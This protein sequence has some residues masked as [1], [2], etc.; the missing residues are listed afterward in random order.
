MVQRKEIVRRGRRGIVAPLAVEAMERA[1]DLEEVPEGARDA[2]FHAYLMAARA[3]RVEAMTNAGLHLLY[4]D[5]VPQDVRHAFRW[6]RKAAGLGDGVAAFNLALSYE[7]GP[8]IR[9]NRRLA[10]YWY[11]RA[12]SLGFPPARMNLAAL[13]VQSS[14]KE[15]LKESVALYRES[16]R[17]GNVKA[18]LYVAFAYEQGRGVR[19]NLGRAIQ[20]YKKAADAGNADAQCVLGWMCLNGVGALQ[21]YWGLSGGT[22]SPQNKVTPVPS[23]AWDRCTGKAMACPN[24]GHAQLG[25]SGWPQLWAILGPQTI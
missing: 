17:L 20:I 6:M 24:P 12:V 15:K 5:G 13:L 25:T 22:N 1:W 10:E 21:T 18:L 3:G 23:L 14:D 8:C 2:L 11:R 4:G 16:A 7:K 19:K 9:P